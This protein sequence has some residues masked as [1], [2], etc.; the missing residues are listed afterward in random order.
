MSFQPPKINFYNTA[1]VRLFLLVLL[2][3]IPALGVQI[4]GAWS[5]LQQTLNERKL[6]SVRVIDHAQGDFN[7][8]L[9]ESRAVFTDLVRLNDIRS[10]NNCTQVFTALRFAY[11]RLAPDAVNLALADTQGNIYCAIN[12]VHG[13]RNIALQSDFQSAIQTLDLSAGVYRLNPSTGLPFVSVS[14]PALS[15]DGKVQTVIVA[16]FETN[17]LENWQSEISLP[18][19]ASVTLLTPNG[20][21]LWQTVSGEKMPVHGLA[22]LE[23]DWFRSL[24]AGETIVEGHDFD[25]V[26]RLH[27]IIT[28]GNSATLH[29]GYPVSELYTQAYAN[30]RWKLGL[31][32][33]VVLFAFG[34]A[35][36]VSE[37]MFLHPLNNLL[38]VV[39]RVQDGDL[40]ARVSSLRGLGELTTL[41][42]SFDQMTDALRQR[43]AERQQMEQRFRAAFESS[44]IG[45]AVMS[46]DG[47]ILAVN[48]AVCAMSG[49]GE[50]E[51]KQRSDSDT[52]YPP[53]AK[54]GR[55]LYVEMLEGKRPHYSVE[56]RY[57]RKNG[58]IFWIRL[59]LSL[60]RD[61]EGQPA[62]LVGQIEDID[63]QKRKS[64]ALAESEARFRTMFETSAIGIGIMGLDGKVVNVNPA[65]CDIFGYKCEELV[66]Q[67]N[68][69]VLHPD[70]QPK[71][72]QSM[73]ELLAGKSNQYS[74][75]RRY[76][77]KNGEVF[78]ARITM[79]M[80]H[81]AQGVPLH[82]VG[83][84]A[85]INEER[86]T[87]VKL[88]ESEARFRAMFEN[89]A[90]ESASSLPK[91]RR[92]R[93]TPRY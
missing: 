79:S 49:Y 78:W 39:K 82:I 75:E 35:W 86:L 31:L 90:W 7:H 64:A 45:M 65:L 81:D 76:I 33:L 55:E 6:E 37:T 77:R 27:T 59:T 41:A 84:V 30:L 73:Q 48:A 8:L 9:I 25:G 34:I 46:L 38:G 51:L 5:D 12:P 69:L 52:V 19:G 71:A 40:N 28:L 21:A 61:A 2:V 93:S 43:E 57:L 17:W 50:D 32:G 85:D 66:G 26:T 23:S 18:V 91:E 89:A 70:D 87:L 83:M 63:E 88:R 67:T 10:T 92:W 29:L 22:V 58:E 15:L 16:T 20:T 14:Y 1:R 24:Q 72:A 36:W 54:V 68:A 13:D 56:R 53:D 44:A 11:E 74:D 60:V 80:V 4:Y 62:Y 3:V 42:H 47:K